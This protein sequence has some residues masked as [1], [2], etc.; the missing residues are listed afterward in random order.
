MTFSFRDKEIEK[1]F[2]EYRIECQQAYNE[3]IYSTI[4][5]VVLES[6]GKR[7]LTPVE[8]SKFQRYLSNIKKSKDKLMSKLLKKPIEDPKESKN[9]KVKMRFNLK[10]VKSEIDND[11]KKM[12]QDRSIIL[13]DH[14]PSSKIK[15]VKKDTAQFLANNGVAIVSAGV[16]TADIIAAQK[17]MEKMSR[18]YDIINKSYEKI[19]DSD[20]RSA[21]LKASQDSESKFGIYVSILLD[22]A[23]DIKF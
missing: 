8:Q 13:T 17:S 23:R 19:V 4:D 22:A 14:D 20:Q 9:K 11:R 12:K 15:K 3:Y 21:A 6:R 10:K 2:L 7:E 5:D 1:A 16:A 18:D